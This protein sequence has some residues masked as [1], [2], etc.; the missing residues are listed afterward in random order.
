MEHIVFRASSR[1]PYLVMTR[2]KLASKEYWHRFERV[3]VVVV[4]VV[5]IAIVVVAVDFPDSVISELVDSM[6]DL[7]LASFETVELA[8][9]GMGEGGKAVEGSIVEVVPIF[10][11]FSK[12]SKNL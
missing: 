9:P 4:V 3:M 10:S 5:F 2:E 12:V 1:P 6:V 8:Y 7:E 11:L